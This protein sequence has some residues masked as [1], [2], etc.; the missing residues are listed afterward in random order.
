MKKIITILVVIVL[1][2]VGLY[3]FTK[4]DTNVPPA[5]TV[6]TPDVSEN[7]QGSGT[8]NEVKSTV[9]S[10]SAIGKSVGGRDIVAY[11]YGTGATKL[12]FVGGIHGGYS[13]NTAL[14]AYELMDYLAKTPTAIPASVQVTVI[15]V[16]NPDGLAKVV[17]NVERFTKAD[18]SPSATTQITGRYNGNTV[19]LNRNF[20]CDW[21]TS[22][23]WQNKT[24]SGGSKA[25]SEPESQAI[26]AY[27]EANNPSAAVIWYSA[28]GG[29][30]SSNCTM[31]VSTTTR[32]IATLYAKASGYPA[33]ES[34]DFYETT[35]DM[36]NWL[37]KK[38]IPAI[39]VLLTTHDDTEW[40]KN[41]AGIE[42]LLKEYAN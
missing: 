21:K 24:V 10:S 6:K 26:K 31:G 11:S 42:A 27:V 13:W 25:F 32:T 9:V 3:F 4:G 8:E 35:G 12:L 17:P 37:A 28:A 14:V 39:S 30:F 41:Q 40:S 2:G 5:D 29:V 22:G 36:A 19:D 18:V 33:H 1:A 20:D 16:V 23:T 38:S 34:F 7:T 15:P